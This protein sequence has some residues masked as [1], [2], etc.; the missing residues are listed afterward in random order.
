MITNFRPFRSISYGYQNKHLVKNFKPYRTYHE[1][2]KIW[3]C[4]TSLFNPFTIW[5]GLSHTFLPPK[6]QKISIK[7]A[8]CREVKTGLNPKYP[9]LVHTLIMSS[10]IDLT[11]CDEVTSFLFLITGDIQTGISVVILA[12]FSGKNSNINYLNCPFYAIQKH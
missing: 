10:I 7:I 2:G 4:V 11:V 12:P 6:F 3:T 9:P 1:M 8:T 5:R